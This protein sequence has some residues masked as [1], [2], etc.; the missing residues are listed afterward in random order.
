MPINL[1]PEK[2]D[3]PKWQPEKEPPVKQAE[4]D[5]VNAKWA[6]IV[7][8]VIY[9]PITF[10]AVPEMLAENSEPFQLGALA[11]MVYSASILRIMRP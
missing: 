3:E 7:G 1:F 4:E 5:I 10:F 6:A 8:V 2:K 11:F 9:V